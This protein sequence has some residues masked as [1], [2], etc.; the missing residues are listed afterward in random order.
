[1]DL[2]NALQRYWDAA[3]AEGQE[4]RNHDTE[5]GRAEQ[6]RRDVMLAVNSKVAAEREACA[7]LA[8]SIND[9]CM[10]APDGPEEI[11]AAIRARSNA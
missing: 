1:M 8:E 3:Y 2:E 9:G 4:G 11:A 5:D 10:G 7:K 6:A